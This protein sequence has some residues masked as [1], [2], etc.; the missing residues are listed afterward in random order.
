MSNPAVEC[1]EH[2]PSSPAFLCA[3]LLRG[4]GLGYTLGEPA[5]DPDPDNQFAESPNA[6][7]TQCEERRQIAGGWSEESEQAAEITVVC[8]S[9]FQ[10]ILARNA[11]T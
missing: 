6:W 8:L 9:C 10:R 5:S 3:H 2:G 7:C 1:A 4:S 11:L